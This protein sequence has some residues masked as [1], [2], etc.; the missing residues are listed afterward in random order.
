M[1]YTLEDVEFL[2][3]YQLL[4]VRQIG[5]AGTVYE[6][7][8]RRTNQLCA[9]KV[10]TLPTDQERISF[11]KEV[12][13]ASQLSR[14]KFIVS[15]KDYFI[16]Q[17]TGVLV[18]KMKKTDL[19]STLSYKHKEASIKPL[20]RQVVVAIGHCHKR[21]IAHLDIKPDNV[22]LSSKGSVALCDFGSAHYFDEPIE[23]PF[24]T[25]FYKAPETRNT[26]QFNKAAAD[27]W[28]MGILLY[29]LL[30]GEYPFRGETEREIAESIQAGTMDFTELLQK[31]FSPYARELVQQMLHIRPLARPTIDDVL[32]SPFFL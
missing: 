3:K 13:I 18:M 20:F 15:V 12:A 16:S 9:T 6:S 19:L 14:C 29:V 31:R 10:M 30:T 25:C 23:R 27:I 8:C 5:G 4:R 22:L 32:D 17:T 11:V 21:K 1:Y 28:S 2:A 7:R 24:G 26:L